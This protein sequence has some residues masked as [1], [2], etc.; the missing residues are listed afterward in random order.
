MV[1]TCLVKREFVALAKDGTP[2]YL[3]V[4]VSVF[5]THADGYA[6]IAFQSDF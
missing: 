1:M 6:S 2:A 3:N 5:R 4:K